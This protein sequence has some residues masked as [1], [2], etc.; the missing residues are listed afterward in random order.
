VVEEAPDVK[1]ACPMTREALSPVARGAEKPTRRLFR[2][3]ATQRSP[4]LSKAIE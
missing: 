1:L 3:S 2:V 4:L